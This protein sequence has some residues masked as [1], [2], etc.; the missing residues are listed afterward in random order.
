[1]YFVNRFTKLN[2]GKSY[3]VIEN[4]AQLMD[5]IEP[6]QGFKTKHFIVLRYFLTKKFN[7]IA[8]AHSYL[9]VM[10]FP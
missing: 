6:V 1:M 4:P 2:T 5:M 10:L 8:E 9:I 7:L 3:Y